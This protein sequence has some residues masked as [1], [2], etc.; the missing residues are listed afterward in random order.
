MDLHLR[1]HALPRALEPDPAVQV[2]EH[3]GDDEDDEQ[4]R[5]EPADCEL[6]EGQAE[7]V[8]ADVAVELRILHAE[9]DAV[10]EEDPARA[11]PPTLRRP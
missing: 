6:E 9:V 5:E 11:T 4:C 3:R 8:E 1:G 10:L 2:V 7:D